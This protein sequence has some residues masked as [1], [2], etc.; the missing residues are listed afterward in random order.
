[1]INFNILLIII[2]LFWSSGTSSSSGWSGAIR[3]PGCA[4]SW[5]W[6]SS[7]SP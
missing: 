6:P 4:A 7:R 3:A 5:S 1:L 2:C